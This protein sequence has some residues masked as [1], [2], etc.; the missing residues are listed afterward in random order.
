MTKL[1][2][3]VIKHL[4]VIKF[5][6]FIDKVYFFFNL[7]VNLLS[8][9]LPF[10]NVYLTRSILNNIH[11]VDI[12]LFKSHLSKYLIFL[13]FQMLFIKLTSILGF[14]IR[15]KFIFLLDSIILSKSKHIDLEDYENSAIYNTIRQIFDQS[16]KS[17]ANYFE[18]FFERYKKFFDFHYKFL[19][20][21][22]IK[23]ILNCS[24]YIFFYT[25]VDSE[26]NNR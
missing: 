14:K 9:L 18:D 2:T 26:P 11:T 6:F 12:S 25:K 20:F 15:N 16:D 24:D 1:K 4:N 8:G 17:V 21:I 5:I 19:F 3:S 22:R 7:Y 10:V 23:C 13:I